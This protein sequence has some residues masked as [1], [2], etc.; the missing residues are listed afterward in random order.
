MFGSPSVVSG[1]VAPTRRPP[2]SCWRSGKMTPPRFRFGDQVAGV[3]GA[4]GVAGD[5]EKLI[6]FRVIE[7]G[8]LHRFAA[9][10]I[11]GF[12]S[13]EAFLAHEGE[14]AA[15]GEVVAGPAGGL[16]HRVRRAR[17]PVGGVFLRQRGDEPHPGAFLP[18]V[19]VGGARS[20]FRAFFVFFEVEDA[21]GDEVDR[22]PVIGDPDRES[23]ASPLSPEPSRGALRSSSPLQP[24]ASPIAP[25][26]QR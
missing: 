10:G 26:T 3:G 22:A 18:E 24:S 20:G 11:I 17:A 7:E 14:V 25:I 2:Q 15:V 23:S 16:A 21:A 13:G 4:A 12:G 1:S 9:L 8:L 5:A 6:F 19:E